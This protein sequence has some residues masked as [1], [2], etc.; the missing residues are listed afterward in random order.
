MTEATQSRLQEL[1][2]HHRIRQLLATYCH[3]CDRDDLAQMASVY[4]EESWDDHGP[5]KCDGK[6]FS[7]IILDQAR[8]SMRVVSHQLGQSLIRIDGDR[9]ATETYFVATLVSAQD[10]TSLTQLG[11]RYV[12]TLERDGDEW[13]IKERL[14]V[15][16]WST[17][18]TIDPGYLAD[19][20]FIEGVRD[21]SDVSWS[22]L[23]RTPQ[24]G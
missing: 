16:D 23:G 10:E 18:G 24:P 2:D 17:S 19:S 15:R 13:R 14:C 4:A 5:N 22:R 7:R 21:A 3:G 9:A 8:Q 20:G 1:W 6:H 11:G 12:D